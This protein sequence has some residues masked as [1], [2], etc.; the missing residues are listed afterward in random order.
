MKLGIVFF[1]CKSNLGCYR[2]FLVRGVVFQVF[3]S[4]ILKDFLLVLRVEGCLKSC[5]LWDNPLLVCW[6]IRRLLRFIFPLY[7]ETFKISFLVICVLIRLELS[8]VYTV[9][10]IFNRKPW[11][12]K[13][14]YF[15]KIKWYLVWMHDN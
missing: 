2:W 3:K 14:V 7:Y 5:L 6:R 13:G 1:F 12:E 15:R 11:Y 4:F 9:S 8:F 10:K